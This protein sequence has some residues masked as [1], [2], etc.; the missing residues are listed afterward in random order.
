LHLNG[1]FS[2]ENNFPPAVG[3]TVTLFATDWE[4]ST[5][6]KGQDRHNTCTGD[7]DFPFEAEEDMVRVT[8]TRTV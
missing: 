8:V 3:A 1:Y 4:M 5:E 2:P 7:D 6:G